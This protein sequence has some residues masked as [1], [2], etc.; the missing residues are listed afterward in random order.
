MPIFFRPYRKVY[1]DG[2]VAILLNQQL[3]VFL[4][5]KLWK[6]YIK[7]YTFFQIM[8]IIF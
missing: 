3:V 1:P 2:A 4:Y 5:P 8:L 6:C 7:S